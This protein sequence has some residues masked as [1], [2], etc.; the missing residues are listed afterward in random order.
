M[1]AMLYPPIRLSALVLAGRSPACSM[2]Q[3]VKAEQW[4]NRKMEGKDRILAESKTVKKDGELELWE[5]P[6]GLFWTP[7]RSRYGLPFHLAEQEMNIYGDEQMGVRKGDIVLDCGANIGTFT[8]T[9]LDRGAKTVVAIEPAPENLECLR[10]TFANEI[11]S[12]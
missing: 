10:R 8:R 11:A 5:T 6:K 7:S 1:A 9:A 3:A 4:R 12:G 2:A